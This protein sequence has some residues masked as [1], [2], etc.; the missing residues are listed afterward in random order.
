MF[1]TA[2]NTLQ[3]FRKARNYRYSYSYVHSNP[4]P[5]FRKI[6]QPKIY[7]DT[8]NICMLSAFVKESVNNTNDSREQE[9]IQPKNDDD[10]EYCVNVAKHEKELKLIC[11]IT[12]CEKRENNI[13]CT[14]ND[15]CIVGKSE[16]SIISDIL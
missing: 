9:H 4:N 13:D 1:R 14:C 10:C 12:G 6:E 2:I 7:N 16:I 8:F 15:K 5:S 11:Q 3:L